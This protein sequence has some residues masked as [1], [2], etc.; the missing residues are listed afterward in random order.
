MRGVCDLKMVGCALARE[1]VVLRVDNFSRRFGKVAANFTKLIR[2]SQKSS[3]KFQ[4]IV[5]NLKQYK[6]NQKVSSLSGGEQQRV[7]IARALVTDPVLLLA[8]E[9]TGNLDPERSKDI[10]NFL[11]KA[12][13]RGT[14]ILV[15]THDPTFIDRYKR[16]LLHLDQGKIV[17]DEKW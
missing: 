8:D 11:L 13:A 16:R 15:A 10:M 7:A 2:K 1:K 12:N 9:P 4:K 6:S 5:T 3:N 14:T 17:Q